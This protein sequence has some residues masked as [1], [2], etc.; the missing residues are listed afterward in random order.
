MKKTE[1]FVITKP[2]Q[3]INARNLV[4]Q[5]GVLRPKLVILDYFSDSF[6][7]YLR[8]RDIDPVWGE[9][10][11]YSSRLS[12]LAKKL[13]K[14]R[15]FNQ[16]Y[17]DSDIYKDSIVNFLLSPFKRVNLYEEGYFSYVGCQDFNMTS[18]AKKMKLFFY[19][20]L[21]LP[22]SLGG[23]FWTNRYYLYVPDLYRGDARVCQLDG[24]VF[25]S[26][27]NELELFCT[28]FS[29]DVNR[30]AFIFESGKK[31]INLYCTSSNFD[32]VKNIV[33]EYEFDL[34]KLHPGVKGLLASAYSFDSNVPIELLIGFLVG[35]GL[36]VNF[37]HEKSSS[38][39]YLSEVENEIIFFDVSNR[40]DIVFENVVAGFKG[41][42]CTY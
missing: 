40:E 1:E 30:C 27:Y 14:F 19:K 24:G 4:R 6:E 23:S 18:S 21:G 12:Y 37:Y 25:R 3:Y 9:V 34:I 16:I 22:L 31:E 42:K 17:V 29:F 15:L 13:T 11:Y 10:E 35:S 26:I 8:V 38:V 5:L 36:K 7:F 33:N 32:N 39:M 41:R 20:M 28:I 2:L